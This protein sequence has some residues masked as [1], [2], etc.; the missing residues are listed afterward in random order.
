M[1]SRLNDDVERSPRSVREYPRRHGQ[2]RR[3]LQEAQG[4]FATIDRL[5]AGKE[6]GVC[7]NPITFAA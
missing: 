2:S 4:K 3:K 7:A 1:T 5:H 6:S